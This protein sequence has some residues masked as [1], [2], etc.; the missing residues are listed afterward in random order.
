MKRN[1][2]AR[3]VIYAVLA[4]V[5]SS[6]LFSFLIMDN[7]IINIG[8]SDGEV[9]NDELTIPSDQVKNIEIDWAAGS[10][11][12]RVANTDHITV[13]EQSTEESIYKLTYKIS[14]NILKLSYASGNI[15][16]GLNKP[17]IPEKTLIITVPENWICGKLQ[18]DGASLDINIE[19]LTVEEIDLDG[20]SCNLEF[21][22]S[23]DQVEIDGASMDI[24]LNCSNR[25]SSIDVDGASCSLDL[26]LPYGCGFVVDVD[27]ISY[28][29]H[30]DLPI[31]TEGDRKVYGDK[32]CKITIDGLSCEVTIRENSV[33]PIE[34]E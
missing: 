24:Q 12:I 9:V 33:C 34:G 26:S 8:S 5:L 30:T 2:I 27:G 18:I 11:E 3:I 6:I 29:F 28:S 23:V 14:G 4:I 22:G 7:F 19:N 13:S 15:S 10:V 20:A 25:V 32:H 16:I 1:A 17:R 31:T 21:L